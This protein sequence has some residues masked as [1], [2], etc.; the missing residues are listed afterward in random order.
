MRQSA[1]NWVI[2]LI[3][4]PHHWVLGSFQRVFAHERGSML[5][6]ASVRSAS[7]V[8]IQPF[9][10]LRDWSPQ[11]VKYPWI[12]NAPNHGSIILPSSSQGIPE[13]TPSMASPEPQQVSPPLFPFVW[14]QITKI[15]PL[16]EYLKWRILVT[17]WPAAL[18][19]GQA[20]KNKIIKGFSL[21]TTYF[22]VLNKCRSSRWGRLWCKERP[23]LSKSRWSTGQTFL[24]W[25]PRG[26]EFL[27]WKQKIIAYLRRGRW[28]F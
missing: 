9:A 22:F 24:T 25:M 21:T 27:V 5:E 15:H 8:R 20:E 26:W 19:S 4:S 7:R 11:H 13:C 10:R 2:Y 28:K 1:C 18:A 3:V 17:L 14:P 6:L 16:P 12:N 23:G